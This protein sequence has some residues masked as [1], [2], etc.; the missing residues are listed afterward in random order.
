M[1][2]AI[3][4]KHICIVVANATD[5]LLACAS[6]A[7]L[8][9]WVEPFAKPIIFASFLVDGYRSAP[10]I[11]RVDPRDPMQHRWKAY[12]RPPAGA[13]PEHRGTAQKATG[14]LASS[15]TLKMTRLT[16]RPTR[17]NE[18]STP[19]FSGSSAIAADRARFDGLELASRFDRIVRPI[20][21]RRAGCWHFRFICE[22]RAPCCS[23]WA[24]R[25][26]R[27][28][29]S[30]RRSGDRS[31]RSSGCPTPWIALSAY[32]TSR[33]YRFTRRQSRS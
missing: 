2:A 1:Y 3:S 32:R 33:H 14:S 8:A 30:H 22:R 25:L 21:R 26:S 31:N 5:A 13:G 28:V 12:Q 19:T 16:Q 4:A 27:L 17:S 10:P 9:G 29:R 20:Y 7:E 24:L 18:L 11:L 23:R 6:I 15:F